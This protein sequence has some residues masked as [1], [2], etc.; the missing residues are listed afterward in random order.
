MKN[1]DSEARQQQQMEQDA[2]MSAV[3]G[4]VR[5]PIVDM[6]GKGGVGKSTVSVNLAAALSARGNRVGLLDVDLHGPNTL[7]MLGLEGSRMG[8]TGERMEP[9]RVEIPGPG[10]L[11][12]VSIAGILDSPDAAVIW[13]G[14]LKIGVI[15]QFL[16][17]PDWGELDYLIVDSPPGT[18]DEPLTVA[19]TVKGAKAVIVTTPQEV[20]L[21]DVRRSI[22]FCSQVNTPVLGLVENMSG[23]VC[24]HCGNSVDIFGQGG[25]ERL[26]EKAGIPFL[27][28]L[29]LDPGMVRASDGGRPYVFEAPQSELVKQFGTIVERIE[30]S[31]TGENA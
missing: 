1:P 11:V 28:R 10:T 29:P 5:R 7:T 12:V 17:D 25:G 8:V 22:T 26:A 31:Y 20:S 14:P 19:Q 27:G 30:H 13:R 2:R 3:L 23:F 4:A 9:L 6:S 15:R 18:G 21:Q 16:A 24:P